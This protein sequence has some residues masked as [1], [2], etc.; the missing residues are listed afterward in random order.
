MTAADS[1]CFH[2]AK[3]RHCGGDL[4]QWY[5]QVSVMACFTVPWKLSVCLLLR[6]IASLDHNTNWFFA[7]NAL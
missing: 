2:G 6:T 7:P 5:Q 3:V 4:G 1:S